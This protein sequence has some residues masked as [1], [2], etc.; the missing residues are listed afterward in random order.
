MANS[1]NKISEVGTPE[2]S[3]LVMVKVRYGHPMIPDSKVKGYWTGTTF[4]IG[5]N[6]VKIKDKDGIEVYEWRELYPNE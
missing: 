1:W 2:K 3:R 5:P 4:R 6:T